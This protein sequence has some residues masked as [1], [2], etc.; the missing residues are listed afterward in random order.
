MSAPIALRHALERVCDDLRRHDPEAR[1]LA[2]A[3][4]LLAGL[5]APAQSA[6]ATGPRGRPRVDPAPIVAA[7]LAGATIEEAA[8]SAG[9]S[10]P[11]A[12]AALK[13]AGVERRR[14]TMHPDEGR[15]LRNQV[16]ATEA[17]AG[18]S[19]ADLGRAHSLSRERVRQIVKRAR[20]V[21]K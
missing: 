19:L 3:E 1:S 18:V 2:Y 9:V 17:A 4:G 14:Y 11:A 15:D 13:R 6:R 20:V 7:Y 5:K 21:D 8:L 10:T 16:I 12:H